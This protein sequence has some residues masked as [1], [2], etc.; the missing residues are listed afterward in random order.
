MIDKAEA[1]EGYTRTRGSSPAEKVVLTEK[2]L[3]AMKAVPA[4]CGR[5]PSTALS[6]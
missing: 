4:G 3:A 5:P 2:G 1:D 6:I